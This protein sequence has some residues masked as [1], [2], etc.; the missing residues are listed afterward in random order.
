MR[1]DW[2]FLLQFVYLLDFVSTAAAAPYSE[3]T[4]LNLSGGTIGSNQTLCIGSI[5]ATLFNINAAS[6]ATGTLAYQWQSSTDGVNFVNIGSATNPNYSPGP[7]QATAFF[8]RRA[9]DGASE[10][11]SNV[12]KVTINEI[13]AAP[14]ITA[15]SSTAFCFGDAV[16]LIAS[17]ADS[18]QWYNDSKLITGA[19]S[20]TLSVTSSGNYTVVVKNSGGCSNSSP[21]TAVIVNPLPETPKI[22]AGSATS[23]CLGE[24]VTLTSSSAVAYQ[25]YK[26]GVLLIG[27]NDQSFTTA[28][29]GTFHVEVTN[30]YGCTST[31]SS[32]TVTVYPVPATPVLA[33]SGATSFCLGGSVVLTSTAASA[34]QWYKDNTLISAAAGATYTATAAGDYS[35]KVKNTFGCLS[36]SSNAITVTTKALPATPVI[37][38]GGPLSFCQ[39]ETVTLTSSSADAYQWFKD[40][41]VVA[42][43]TGQSISVSATG[44]YAVVVTNSEG[45]KSATGSNTVVTVN[46]L[47]VVPIITAGGPLTFC[48]GGSVRLTAPVAVNYQWFK[49]GT[50]ITGALSQTYTATESAAYTVVVKNAAGCTSGVSS[51]T[52]VL[53]NPV[54]DAPGAITGAVKVFAGATEIYAVT[55]VGG[56]TSYTW[57]IPSGWTGSST[58]N[59][60]SVKV[61]NLGGSLSVRSN[62]NG[63]SSVAVMLAVSILPDNDKDNIADDDDPD[64]DN[65]GIADVVENAACTPASPQ[66]DTDGDGIPNRFDLDSDGDGIPDASE[67]DGK[68]E[69]KDGKLEP[70][71]TDS[72]NDGIPDGETLLVWKTASAPRLL[73]DG[74]ME[75]RYNIVVS[76]ARK[77]PITHVQLKEDLTKTFVSPMTFSVIE[78]TTSGTL[79]KAVGF[80]GR[81]SINL[82]QTG[83][84]LPGLAKDSISLLVRFAPNGY[85]GELTNVVDGY[86]LA[87]WFNVERQSIDI[88][89]SGGRRHG[90]GLPT[91]VNIPEVK[92]K[93]PDVIT[94]NGDGLNDRFTILRPSNVRVDLMIFN[95]RGV[96]VFKADDYKNTWDGSSGT[97]SAGN[98]LP[99][100]TYFYV[101]T[102]SGG[103]LTGKEIRKGYLMLKRD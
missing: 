84:I 25:W 7:L 93:I 15:S 96:Q 94:P 54:P 99:F 95:N 86:A 19:T 65:D 48:S 78:L 64:D 55:A 30:Q 8:R 47:P 81:S 69:D 88:S 87:R 83:T 79:V 27:A 12:I 36:E 46:A 63:C 67:A 91:V 66:C 50:A 53:V 10:A 31:G 1:K 70:Y 28:V 6:G 76:N 3:Q 37:T 100:G 20:Q 92:I 21:S 80:D 41:V 101:A 74:T 38:A 61:G 59:S 29:S 103:D 33:A 71:D 2:F 22:T 62:L 60:I 42:S 82:L 32:T 18:Y 97:G 51:A 9:S 73:P 39:G 56:T 13:P 57:S 11:F 89:R 98:L 58:G 17:Q 14:S 75:L 102:F 44:N 34:Y 26:D 4:I 40:G 16:Q 23:F 52:T 5:P 77:E 45:C 43:T 35:I 90:A 24:S 49:D 68:D 72:N 85:K